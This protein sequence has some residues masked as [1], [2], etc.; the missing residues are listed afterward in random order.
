MTTLRSL[1]IRLIPT[2]NGRL[3]ATPNDLA[4]AAFMRLLGHVNPHL[5]TDL[6]NHNGRKPFTLSPLHGYQRQDKHTLTIHHGQEGWLR[7]TLLDDTLFQTFIA[8]FLNPGRTQPTITLHHIPFLITEILSQPQTHQLAQHTTLTQLAQT[9][10]THPT[11]HLH[12]ATPTAF[13]LHTNGHRHMHILPDPPLLFG[14]LAT[15]WDALTNDQT[16]ETI[17]HFTAQHLVVA[18][19]NL[20]T[21]MIRIK[22]H[23]QVGFEGHTTFQLLR[24]DQP[25][26]TAHLHRLAQLAFYTGL[27]SRTTMGMGQIRYTLPEEEE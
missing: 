1:I 15:Y 11:L 5:A 7:L 9:H 17:R 26:L 4:H 18:H 25:D 8:Y 6:H 13:S 19:Y 12:F 24:H 2:T 21:R 20:Q 16:H 22:N 23:P 27:G 14:Q 10:T 3:P